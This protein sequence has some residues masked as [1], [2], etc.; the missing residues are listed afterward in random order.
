M[1]SNLPQDMRDS[2]T[3][4]GGPV[5]AMV[6]WVA[7]WISDF[8]AVLL[9]WTASLG[10]IAIFVMRTF[11]WLLGRLPKKETLT[12]NFYEIGVLSLPVV[13]LTGTFIGM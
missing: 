1:Q 3:M 13:A 11:R 9:D 2:P 4:R 8:G 10:S 12:P 5:G 6:D 7:D